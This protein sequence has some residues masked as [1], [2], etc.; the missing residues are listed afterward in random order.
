M[1]RTV[2]VW[3]NVPSVSRKLL[4]SGC[5][6]RPRTQE[7]LGSGR[8]PWFPMLNSLDK[9]A[10]GRVYYWLMEAFQAKTPFEIQALK[11]SSGDFPKLDRMVLFLVNPWGGTGRAVWTK[12]PIL[13]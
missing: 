7:H 1:K 6:H 13:H 3:R 11:E 4:H 2:G 10:E 9:S 5:Q 12:N 8:T